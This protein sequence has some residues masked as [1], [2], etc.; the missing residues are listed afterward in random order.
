MIAATVAAILAVTYYAVGLALAWFAG[1]NTVQRLGLAVLFI[2]G[3][4]AWLIMC[5]VVLMAISALFTYRAVK[6]WSR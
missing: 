3:G 5:I 2:I 1:D 4:F 6:K